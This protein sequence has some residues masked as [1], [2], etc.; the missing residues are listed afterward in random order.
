MPFNR[1]AVLLVSV[2]AA[3]GLTLIVALWFGTFTALPA[4][5]LSALALAAAL[6]VRRIPK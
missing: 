4:G 3:A 2:I 5:L 6:L 1:F